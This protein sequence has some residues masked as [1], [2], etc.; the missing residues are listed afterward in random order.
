MKSFWK[1]FEKNFSSVLL[2]AILIILSIQVFA[3]YLFM[4]SPSWSEELA[5]YLFIWFIYTS[6]SFAAQQ[7][8]HIT[9]DSIMNIY[10]EK[11]KTRIK[12]L[13]NV[14]WIVFNLV[15][16]YFGVQ[17]TYRL[18]EVNQVS[19]GVPISMWIIYA[20]IPFGYALMSVRLIMSMI[21]PTGNT[22]A[23]DDEIALSETGGI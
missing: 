3:R 13:G 1:N 5:R 16:V 14:V 9:I 15:M 20:A 22:S 11:W 2:V 8:A 10:P 6:V 18:Y 12:K 19:V 17:Y 7:N 23:S 21:R 4:Y